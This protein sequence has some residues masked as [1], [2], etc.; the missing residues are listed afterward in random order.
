M[1]S[2]IET[3]GL[4]KVYSN[5]KGEDVVAI[6]SLDLTVGQP[7][8][9]HGF[10]GPNGSGKTTSIRCLLGLIRPTSG[11]A[12][13][14]GADSTTAFHEVAHRVGAIV[15]NPKLFPN[16][17]AQRNLTLLADLAGVPKT[18]VARVMEVVGL[19]G[20]ENDTFEAYSLGMKQRLAIAAALLKKPELLVLDEPANGLDPA[21][22]A[23]MRVLIRSIAAEGTSVLVSSHQLAEI[24]QMCD[25]V[26]IIDR[27][28]LVTTGLVDEVRRHAGPD[29]VVVSIADTN[30][31]IQALATSG[32][33]ARPRPTPGELTVDVDATETAA[34]TKALADQGLYLTG[35]RSE[36]A[37]L[38]NAFLNLTGNTAPPPPGSPAPTG[39]TPGPGLDGPP[40][41]PPMARPPGANA[42]PA[43]APNHEESA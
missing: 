30:A 18:E 17:T 29:S 26:T 22:I 36:R 41:A 10:L 3:H 7:G 39:D 6:E 2:I 38:E 37:T 24:E 23:E 14:F 28:K 34:V 4:R 19:T 25:E 35:L 42:P 40:T 13:L 5:R 33:G 1:P 27:G 15:E 31:A 21:G 43:P 9:I 11:S 12:T 32:I 16:F 8:T 20:R